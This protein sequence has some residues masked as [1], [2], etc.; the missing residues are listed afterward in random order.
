VA[1]SLLPAL[2]AIALTSLSLPAAAQPGR[3]GKPGAA[4]AAAPAA[5]A[6]RPNA[7]RPMFDRRTG[8]AET[9]AAALAAA[10]AR[11]DKA[12][13]ARWAERLGPSRLGQM[14][15]SD[16]RGAVLAAL[17]GT[18]L[19]DGNVRLLPWVTRLLA[20]NDPKVAE[21]AA[22]TLAELLAADRLGKLLEWE[23]AGPEVADACAALARTADHGNA[24]VGL[25]VAALGAL[26]EAHAF[27][28]VSIPLGTLSGDVWPEVRRA[29]LLAP[30][31][32]RV[33]SVETIGGMSAD[34][35]P[36]VAG[37]AATVWCRHRLESLRKGP[38]GDEAKQRLGRMRALVM[39]DNTPAEDTVEMLPCLAVSPNPEDKRALELARKKR[40]GP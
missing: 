24:P 26:A 34:M 29:A 13:V 20:D 18:K 32:V 11:G 9:P 17:E 19:L 6:A 2:G 37:A 35:V 31:I 40:G 27:C 22:D 39:M 8:L 28:R 16:D 36:Q 30:Q 21:R 1:R 4:A 25:R 38:L 7:S 23:I 12:D 33:Q 15:A 14:L 10:A 3:P 5:A